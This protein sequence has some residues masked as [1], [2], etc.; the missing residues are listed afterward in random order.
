MTALAFYVKI[1]TI[2]QLPLLLVGL[3]SSLAS[4]SINLTGTTIQALWWATVPSALLNQNF[5]VLKALFADYNTLSSESERA[6]A[7]GSLGMA[8]GVAFMVG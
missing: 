7:V 1:I 2:S 8:A 3:A 6:S 5:S 4:Y